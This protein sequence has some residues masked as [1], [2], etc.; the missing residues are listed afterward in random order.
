MSCT[1]T[2]HRDHVK[3]VSFRLL[4]NGGRSLSHNILP[5]DELSDRLLI[6]I[7]GGIIKKMEDFVYSLNNCGRSLIHNISPTDQLPDSPS[8]H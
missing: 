3:L 2:L 1:S 7:V 5:T 4:E 8:F 6:S